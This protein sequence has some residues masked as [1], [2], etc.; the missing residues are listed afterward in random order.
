MTRVEPLPH[1]AAM[2]PMAAAEPLDRSAFE[3]FY[4]ATARALLA[5]IR[6]VSGDA[7]ADDILQDAYVRLLAAP[8]AQLDGAQIKSYLYKTA[9][10]LIYDRWRRQQRERKWFELTRWIAREH[11]DPSAGQELGHD[12]QKMFLRLKPQERALLWLAYVEGLDHREIANVLNLK[13][14]SI[15]VMLFRAR[16]KMEAILKRHGL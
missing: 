4:A 7:G 16:Q 3:A 11:H 5:Y 10:S 2:E 12:M 9:T 13:E 15:R 8:I 14:T 6:R 1:S